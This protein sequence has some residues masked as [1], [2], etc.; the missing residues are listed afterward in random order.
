[1]E[2]GK[3]GRPPRNPSSRS[4]NYAKHLYRDQKLPIAEIL[5]MLNVSKSTL[6]RWLD[7]PSQREELAREKRKK[8]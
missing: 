7:L 3:G 6:Y 1:M 5:K 8:L 2:W 4:V